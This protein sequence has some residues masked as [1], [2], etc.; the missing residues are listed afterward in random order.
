MSVAE[1]VSSFATL[2]VSNVNDKATEVAAKV[3]DDGI[4]SMEST[5][6]MPELQ[7]RHCGTVYCRDTCGA[8]QPVRSPAHGVNGGAPT[9]MR[10]SAA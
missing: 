5:N 8:L 3:S 9:P 6:L 4:A 7:V 10:R 2:E 1:L